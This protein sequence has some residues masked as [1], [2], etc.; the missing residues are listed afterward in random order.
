MDAHVDEQRREKAEARVPFL[1]VPFS[2]GTQRKDTRLE[3]K[4]NV[5]IIQKK[6]LAE[7]RNKMVKQRAQ[8][9]KEIPIKTSHEMQHQLDQPSPTP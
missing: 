1:L 5:Q 6:L 2:L 8:P 9:S 4:N 3:A 7:W